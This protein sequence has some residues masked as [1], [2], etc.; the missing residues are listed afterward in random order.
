M[1]KTAIFIVLGL[2]LAAFAP[3]GSAQLAEA[4]LSGQCYDAAAANGGEDEARVNTDGDVVVLPDTQANP[5]GGIPSGTGGAVP[6]LVLF[7][8][9][10]VKDGGQTGNACKRPD[11]YTFDQCNGRPPRY[12]YLEVHVKAGDVF[13][14][15]CY[16]GS[17]NLA[18]TCPTSPTGP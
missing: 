8:S 17:V 9:E 5:T 18:G 13:L 10:S 7:A 2:A 1:Y 6:A 4:G 3:S 12:D 15:A 16:S 11:C 14:Q